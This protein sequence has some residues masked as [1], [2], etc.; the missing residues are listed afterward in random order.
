MSLFRR[1]EFSGEKSRNLQV[2]SFITLFSVF[3][4]CYIL[5]SITF[6]IKSAKKISGLLKIESRISF[7]QIF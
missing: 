2:F 5:I 1:P 4:L 6:R 7:T 3:L